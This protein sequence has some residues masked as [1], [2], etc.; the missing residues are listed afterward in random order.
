MAKRLVAVLGVLVLASA[1]AFVPHEVDIEAHAPRAGS[2]IGEGVAIDLQVI[3]DRE[4]TDIGKRA[5][6]ELAGDNIADNVM[7]VLEREVVAIFDSH[8]F[9]VVP[10][11][12][13]YDTDVEVRLRSFRFIL[14]S[15]FWTGEENTSIVVAVEAEKGDRDF[16]RTY[17]SISKESIMFAPGES[18]IDDALSVALS[19]VLRQLA[20]DRD[21]MNFM[22]R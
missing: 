8:S 12:S 21:L 1:C 6:G 10:P 2:T 18:A 22:A 20:S 17:R 11:G 19:D 14:E 15:G 4:T 5:F 9:D 13:D 3:D 7:Q 16:D